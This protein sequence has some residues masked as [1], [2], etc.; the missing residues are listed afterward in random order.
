VS[1]ETMQAVLSSTTRT[2][3]ATARVNSTQS[4][5]RSPSA[6]PPVQE[7]TAKFPAVLAW[8]CHGRT[9]SRLFR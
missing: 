4:L 3:G 6:A 7:V 2:L 5:L 1:T 9:L 8:E